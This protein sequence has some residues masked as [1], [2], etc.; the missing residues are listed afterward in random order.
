MSSA[1]PTKGLPTELRKRT[2]HLRRALKAV[3]EYLGADPT[4]PQDLAR[5]FS[6][7]KN[8]TWKISRIVQ[9]DDVVECM[10]VM[11][12]PEGLEIFMRAMA[13]AGARPALIAGVR[14]ELRLL[15][16]TIHQHLTDRD[17]LEV[18]LDGMKAND[19]LELSRRLQHRGMCGIVGIKCRASIAFVAVARSAMDPDMADVA[20]IL[21]NVGEQCLRELPP[22]RSFT[23]QSSA[24]KAEPL[25]L[26]GTTGSFM[27]DHLSSCA[28]GTVSHHRNATEEWFQVE[29]RPLGRSGDVTIA[30]GTHSRAAVS[31]WW[32]PDDPQLDLNARVLIPTE[33]KVQIAFVERDLLESPVPT[34]SVLSMI[35][36]A[37]VAN[38]AE[39]DALRIPIPVVST[40]LDPLAPLA[41]DVWEDAERTAQHL[42]ACTGWDRS[43][44]CVHLS[45]VQYPPV[46]SGLCAT[47]RLKRKP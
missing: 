42:F 5:Q 13:T 46:P 26:A 17:E 38:I 3:L 11:P 25:A 32:S 14:D 29:P 16:H 31:R 10:R 15:D 47:Y 18:V 39:R 35:Q 34:M 33:T 24:G 23:V 43:R 40:E 37:R 2:E 12:G 4:R 44:F 9:S 20:L 30:F 28:P 7:N 8:L 41:L 36:P 21:A 22:S 6:L 19:T 27:L 45:E 1:E